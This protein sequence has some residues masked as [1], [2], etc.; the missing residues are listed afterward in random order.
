[1][2]PVAHSEG[3]VAVVEDLPNEPPAGSLVPDDLLRRMPPGPIAEEEQIGTPPDAFS[4][5]AL[6]AAYTTRD[7]AR[8]AFAREQL[9]YHDPLTGLWN[10]C[11]CDDRFLRSSRNVQAS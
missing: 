10:R 7:A 5:T 6:A 9:A 11:A 3:V 2:S 4:P 8:H 1:V